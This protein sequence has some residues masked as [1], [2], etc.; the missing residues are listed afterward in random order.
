MCIYVF[1]SLYTMFPKKSCDI[2]EVTM[3]HCEAVRELMEFLRAIF[4]ECQSRG[5]RMYTLWWCQSSYWKCKLR[6]SFPI[7]NG[8]LNPSYVSLPEGKLHTDGHS[9]SMFSCSFTHFLPQMST[10]S[11]SNTETNLLLMIKIRHCVQ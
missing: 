1:I 8:D 2:T 11:H 4:R 6:V 3:G 5:R 10:I 9:M 7:E